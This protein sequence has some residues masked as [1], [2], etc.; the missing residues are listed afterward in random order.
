MASEGQRKVLVHVKIDP[1]VRPA[2]GRIRIV[3]LTPIENQEA[4]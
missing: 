4:H 2:D 1:L 3:Y